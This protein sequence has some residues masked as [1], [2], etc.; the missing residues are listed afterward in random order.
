[1]EMKIN[2]YSLG[3]IITNI[4]NYYLEENNHQKLSYIYILNMIDDF[5]MNDPIRIIINVV[6]TIPNL[7]EE[8]QNK[9]I[10]EIIDDIEFQFKIKLI[11]LDK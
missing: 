5:E 2:N 4:I 3:N 6:E 7:D 8:T 1:M 10:N 9:I 11:D